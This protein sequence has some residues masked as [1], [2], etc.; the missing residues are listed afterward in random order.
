[1]VDPG[2][3]V[4]IARLQNQ[5][6]QHLGLTAEEAVFEFGEEGAEATL[7]LI[8]INP[9][10]RQAFLFHDTRGKNKVVALEQMMEYVASYRDK[11]GS[12]TIQWAVRGTNRLHT[13]YFRGSDVFDVLR[14][15]TFGRD[16]NTI[17]IYGVTLNPVA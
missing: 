12:Y 8:T 5:I 14:K 16:R 3:H 17:L 13:S 6:L 2:N 15:F 9:D 10:H 4:Q 7:S 11:E 1:M